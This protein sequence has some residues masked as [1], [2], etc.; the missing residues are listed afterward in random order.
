MH[1]RIVL[2]H[3]ASLAAWPYHECIHW[4]FD[5]VLLRLQHSL[6]HICLHLYALQH[7]NY[8]IFFFQNSHWTM[9]FKSKI[10]KQS[11]FNYS[12][13]D[14]MLCKICHQK[15]TRNIENVTHSR[16]FLFVFCILYDVKFDLELCAHR[17]AIQRIVISPDKRTCI[18]YPFFGRNTGTGTHA[19]N[20]I[21]SGR[22]NR[23]NRVE[24]HTDC[25]LS[26]D[27][28]CRQ[29]VQHS[30]TAVNNFDCVRVAGAHV[31]PF[32]GQ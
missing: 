18:N 3:F 9:Q 32:T 13:F 27:V 5:M 22:P 29:C 15:K 17:V 12:M 28:C 31:L 10:A 30:C 21:F 14:T 8:P 11:Y 19:S 4:T 7:K 2:G 23:C 24:P 20:N 1:L 16:V 6:R 25:E 26:S